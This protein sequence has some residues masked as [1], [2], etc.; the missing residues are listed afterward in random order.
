MLAY[1]G[2]D[3]ILEGSLSILEASL[4][5]ITRVFF[6]PWMLPRPSSSSSF[7]VPCAHVSLFL[8]EGY[9]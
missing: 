9:R 4:S 3:E 1:M 6:S 8:L 7:S 5:F 2:F